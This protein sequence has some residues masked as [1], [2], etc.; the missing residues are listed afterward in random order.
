[1][2]ARVKRRMYRDEPYWGK[3]VP[4]FG[5]PRARILILGLAPAAHGANRTGR[6]FT[7][8]RSGLWL[9]RALWRAGF[10]DRERSESRDDGLTLERVRITAACRCAPPANRP[11]PEELKA[12]AP[13]LSREFEL[14]PSLA[15]VVALG[16]IGWKAALTR[17]L[18]VDPRGMPKPRPR[19]AHL[20]E[21]AL[22]FREGGDRI[23]LLGSYHPSQQNTQTG[24]LKEPMLDAVFARARALTDEHR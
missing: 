24:R 14:L 6:M 15:V 21:T 17:S 13:F 18:E 22:R 2:V 8:D 9:Y 5:D 10:A 3:P 7:G 12:C 16:G 1:M 23:R 20:A 11:T 19:F 4:S